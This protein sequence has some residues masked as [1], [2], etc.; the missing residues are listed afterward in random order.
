MPD[1]AYG[2]RRMPRPVL[3]LVAAAVLLPVALVSPRGFSLLGVGFDAV[4]GII[5]IG[6][7][8]SLR[9]SPGRWLGVPVWLEVVGVGALFL[10]LAAFNAG[11]TLLGTKAAADARA[12]IVLSHPAAGTRE[13]TLKT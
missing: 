1:S 9:K 2:V 12:R 11:R 7:G 10:A 3:Y 5:L 4:A 8:I 6:V 13:L